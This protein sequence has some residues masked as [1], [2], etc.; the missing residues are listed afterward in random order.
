MK[1]EFLME[2]LL[3]IYAVV[4]QEFE[5]LQD[6]RMIIMNLVAKVDRWYIGLIECCPNFIA[7]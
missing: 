5:F 2:N 4:E 7:V 1:Y 6:I 3:K